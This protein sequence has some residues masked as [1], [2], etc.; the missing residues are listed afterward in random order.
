[1]AGANSK[2]KRKREDKVNVMRNSSENKTK[3]AGPEKRHKKNTE[4]THKI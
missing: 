2:E 4:K 1:M 3:E